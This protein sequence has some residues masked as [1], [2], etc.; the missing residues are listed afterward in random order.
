MPTYAGNPTATEATGDVLI[1]ARIAG[2]KC[3]RPSIEHCALVIDAHNAK[4][5][6]AHA[7]RD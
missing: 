3:Y 4:I 2:C 1:V 5:A 6:K 7:A